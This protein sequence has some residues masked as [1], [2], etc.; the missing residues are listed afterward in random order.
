M[1]NKVNALP[2]DKSEEFGEMTFIINGNEYTLPNSDWMFEA[3][4]SKEPGQVKKICRSVVSQRD[5]RRDMFIIGD[6]FIRNYYSIF[7]RDNDRVG[8]AKKAM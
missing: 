4:D 8:L 5:V 3:T 6:I 1:P 2:C 7:D